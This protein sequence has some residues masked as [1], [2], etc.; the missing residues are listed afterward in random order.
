METIQNEINS[1]SVEPNNWKKNAILFLLSQSVSLFGSSIVQYAII[2][3]ITL[4]TGSGVMMTLATLCGFLPQIFVSVFAGVWADRF[5]KKILI[6]I[7][8]ASIALSTLILAIF[9]LSGVDSIWLLLV[10][11]GIRSLGSGVQT[12]AVNALLPT[13][14][15][16]KHLLRINGINSTVQS[17]ILIVSPLVA[18]GLM[19]VLPIGSIF[20]VDVITAI[21]GVGIFSTIKIV[22]KKH[23][24]TG[25]KINYF[26][27]FKEGFLYIKNDKFLKTYML[28]FSFFY[29]LFSP[30]AFLTPLLIARSF[31]DEVW[32]LTANEVI[33]FVGTII[34]GGLMATWG[35]FK[36]KIYTLCLACFI[37]SISSVGLGLPINFIM[38]LVFIG[39]SGFGMSIM[40]TP[41]MTVLQESVDPSVQGRIFS[42]VQILSSII[43]PLSML[44]FG[45]LSDTFSV[46][47]L[48]II[49]GIATFILTGFMITNKTLI[50]GVKINDTEKEKQEEIKEIDPIS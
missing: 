46:Q 23:K 4:T 3:H 47:I 38:Y 20:F 16:E 14:V 31:G 18:G 49:T 28:F 21:I 7:S 2:W 44:I 34:G 25:E 12:P 32:R 13:L 36:N 24:K 37:F 27:D 26:A 11:L 35:G 6:M 41:S 43:M 40:Q 45:P 10:G 22:H 8:D 9:F 17:V 33:F 39:I 15:P 48:I 42:I 50:N 30:V 5:N 19:G 29:I 1:D